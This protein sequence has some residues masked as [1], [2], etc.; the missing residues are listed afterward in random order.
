M[1]PKSRW[2]LNFLLPILA[3]FS[4]QTLQAQSTPVFATYNGGLSNSGQFADCTNL[5]DFTYSVTGDF[6]PGDTSVPGPAQVI[7]NNGGGFETIFGQADEV[8]NIEVEVAGVFGSAGDPISNTVVTTITFT[9]PVPANTLGF[10]I[11]DV[12]QDQVTVCA[13]DAAG[14]VPI[15]TIA[16]WHQASFDA[17]MSDAGTNPP[18]WDP[19]T[20]TLVGEF[21]SAPVQQTTYV[22]QLPDNEAGAA[23]FMVDVPITQLQFK[24]Q[25]L[26]LA[27]DDPSQ[28]FILAAIC[29]PCP[30][31]NCAEIVIID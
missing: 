19:A 23:W 14:D 16:N 31:P 26:G 27:P 2:L 7:D 5:P 22:T 29:T 10:I 9:S 13:S 4:V 6:A 1:Q 17:D 11:A 25:A 3:L 30:V 20:G 12:E 15:S 24:S 28:H 18:S 21:S 8:E